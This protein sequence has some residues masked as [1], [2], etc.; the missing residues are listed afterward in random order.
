MST[1]PSLD[2]PAPIPV[3]RHSRA[4]RGLRSTPLAIVVASLMAAAGPASAQYTEYTGTYFVPGLN[5]TS[6][7]WNQAY[8]PGRLGGRIHLGQ[9]R[10]P[11]LTSY[12]E[13]D[14]QSRE[15]A[16]IVRSEAAGTRF[17][18]VGHSMGGPIS[19][20]LLLSPD[21]GI[22]TAGKIAGI[23]TVASPNIGAPVAAQGSEYDPR[24]TLGKI[25]GFIRTIITGALHPLAGIVDAL[26]ADYVN[27]KLDRDLF[28]KL[29]EA[30]KGLSVPGAIDLKPSSP[31][32][33]RIGGAADGAPH[34][35]VWGTV[36][37][38]YSWARIAGSRE[39][40]SPEAML[41]T[42]KKGRTH[43]RICRAILYNVIIKTGAGKACAVGDRA[44]GG[45]DEKWKEWVHFS[46]NRNS[47]TDG[48]LPE[49]TLRY[50]FEGDP[51]KQLRAS[52]NEDH[53]SIVW[54]DPG[55][56]R[57]GDGMLAAK[58]R[59]ADAP[60]PPPDNPPPTGGCADPTQLVCDP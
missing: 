7:I 51:G 12:R 8:T 24:T 32:I 52:G 41:Q 60:P 29:K 45:F 23:V 58:M 39:F 56:I 48:L 34:A 11:N 49:E 38:Q 36:P 19:R 47:P 1:S 15:L 54:R 9:T 43:L 31:N 4:A 5:E 22:N 3:A 26:L 21:A 50:P 59:P 37:Q 13:L 57:I 6:A 18:F 17:Y 25:E 14:Y 42:V 16:G 2:T 53:Y 35:A 40:K 30:A 28:S 44:I 20:N 10:V 55:V 46:S 27:D 33:Q